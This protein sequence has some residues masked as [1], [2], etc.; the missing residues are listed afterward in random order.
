[1]HFGGESTGSAIYLLLDEAV[2]CF[3]FTLFAT[4]KAKNVKSTGRLGYISERDRAYRVT[5][6]IA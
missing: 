1:M 2:S 5:W 4:R 3:P 6:E